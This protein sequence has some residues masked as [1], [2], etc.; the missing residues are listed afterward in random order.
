MK[1]K[2]LFI[3]A[4]VGLGLPCLRTAADPSPDEARSRLEQTLQEKEQVIQK[5]ERENQNLKKS[6]EE[7]ERR[8]EALELENRALRDRLEQIGHLSGDGGVRPND[9]AEP[10]GPR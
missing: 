7:M 3:A 5:L 9:G 1:L 10:F 2:C 4:L 6:T 8:I